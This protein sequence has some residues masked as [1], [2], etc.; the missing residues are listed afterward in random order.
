MRTNALFRVKALFAST[1]TLFIGLTADLPSAV[2]APTVTGT[3][4][5]VMASGGQSGYFGHSSGGSSGNMFPD[6]MAVCNGA[7]APSGSGYSNQWIGGSFVSAGEIN[8]AFQQQEVYINNSISNLNTNLRTYVDQRVSGTTFDP[9]AIIAKNNEQDGRLNSA[10]SRLNT[11]EGKI[12]AAQNTITQHTQQIAAVE[13]DVAAVESRV[14]VVEAKNT[15][16][17]A[18][19]DANDLKN[20]EQDNRLTDVEAKNADQDARLDQHDAILADHENRIT[21]TEAKNAEQDGR[22][23]Q[24]DATLADHEGRITET[25]KGIKNISDNAV[26][27][28]RDLNGN[29]SGG[30]TLDDGTG[31]EVQLGNVAAGKDGTDA[32]NV[33]QLQGALDGLGGGAKV[34]EDGSTSSP[35]YNVGG[36]DYNNVGD[37]LK[38]TNSLGVQYVADENGKPTNTVVLIG[39][40]TGPVKITNVA[41]G[42]ED[43]DAVNY[44]QVKDNISYDRNED[45]SR[46]NTI[47][48]TGGGTGPV[49]IHNVADGKIDGDAATVRQV[50]Q[51]RQDSYDYTDQRISELTSD[52]EIKFSAL[53]GEISKTRQEMRAGI[54]SAMA[55]ASL[56]FDDRP[57]KLS[58]AGSM[59][60]FKGSTSIATGLGY[61]SEDGNWRINAGIAHSFATNDTSWNAGASFTLN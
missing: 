9:S 30:L 5:C 37:A 10:E 52:S 24:H 12:T 42:T 51:A 19:L 29:K 26:F 1:A 48:L 6:Y 44:G 31:K 61:T 58:I 50:K 2:A 18:R 55:A 20:T 4:G 17:D 59:G 46:L 28:D 8:S 49:T 53:S 40:G 27:Y 47:T 15:E 33:N 57:G 22:L 25:E 14:D 35:T 39:D 54:A 43:S 32:T 36:V 56:R 13:N 23:D 16:Q 60:G 41:A 45:G 3:N 38:A 34:N 21:E 7:A 11:A